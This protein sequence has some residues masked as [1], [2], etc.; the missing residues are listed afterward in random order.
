MNAAAGSA[1]RLNDLELASRMSFFLWGSV[2]DDELLQTATRGKLKD[3]SVL[4]LQVRR[5]LKDP[6]SKAL[7]DNFANRWLELSKLPGFVPDTGLFQEFDENLR[8]AMAQETQLFVESQLRENHS[9]VDLLTADY[10]YVNERLAKHYGI[11]DIYG[12][13]LR[14]VKFTDGKR[15]GLLG[16]GAVLSVTS[17]PNRTSVVM[18]GRWLLA[19]VLGAPPPPPPAD[20]PALK[21]PGAAG[22]PRSLRE[23]ME[24]H[25]K[26]AVCASCHQRMDPLGFALENFDAVGKWRTE[27]DGAPIDPA[28]TF[29]DGSRFSGASGLRALLA[30]HK[31]DFART[32]TEKLMAFAVGRGIEYTDLPAI[33]KIARDAAPGDYRWSSII[34]GI[35]NSPPFSMATATGGESARTGAQ[36]GER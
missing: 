7:V 16:Q 21:E 8:E 26:D 11:P 33:R 18:R 36:T 6:R 24:I 28:A 5:M 22:Q 15:G 30:S 25:R 12:N 1:Y 32:L 34:L 20:V 17:Y 2:P 31:E 9:V 27:S 14:P 13:R 3:P 19:N 23:R 10:S 29:P 4:E 35:I